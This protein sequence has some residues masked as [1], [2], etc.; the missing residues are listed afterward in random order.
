MSIWDV[1]V[2]FSIG[3]CYITAILVIV[4]WIRHARNNK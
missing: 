1:I 3:V 4:G 2:Y